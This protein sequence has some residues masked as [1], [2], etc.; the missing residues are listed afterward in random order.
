[1][2]ATQPPPPAPPPIAL[3]PPPHNARHRAKKER[4]LARRA[5]EKVFVGMG[6]PEARDRREEVSLRAE[7]SN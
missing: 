6:I 4:A 5:V 3:L 1:M 2:V 7:T